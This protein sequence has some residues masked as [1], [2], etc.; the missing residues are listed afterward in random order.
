VAEVLAARKAV[1]SCGAVVA[2]LVQLAMEQRDH[3]Q[4]AKRTFL[5]LVAG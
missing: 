2:S 4:K 1:F 3:G 5:L